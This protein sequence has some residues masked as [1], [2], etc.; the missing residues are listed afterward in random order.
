M[1]SFLNTKDTKYTK[2]KTFVYFVFIFLETIINRII[3]LEVPHDEQPST[4]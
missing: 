2:G 1:K 4:S 3:F